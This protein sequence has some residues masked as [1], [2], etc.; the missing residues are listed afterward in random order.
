MNKREII[1]Q[2]N[3]NNLHHVYKYG[4]IGIDYMFRNKQKHEY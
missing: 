4:T 3:R 1:N 2:E